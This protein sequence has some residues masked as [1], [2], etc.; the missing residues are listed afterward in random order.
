MFR[1]LSLALLGMMIGGCAASSSSIQAA[2]STDPQNILGK[3]WQWESTI[4]PVEKITV[5]D[6][7]G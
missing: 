1:I 3:T 7:E 5:Q 2:H 4:T 6:P